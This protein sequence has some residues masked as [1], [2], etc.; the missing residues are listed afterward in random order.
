M[1]VYIL[2]TLSQNYLINRMK[3]NNPVSLTIEIIYLLLY[4]ILQYIYYV[5]ILCVHMYYIY[6]N[7]TFFFYTHICASSIQ[8]NKWKWFY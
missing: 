7:S 6:N 5:S 4:Y 2:V 8:I 1:F 3:M